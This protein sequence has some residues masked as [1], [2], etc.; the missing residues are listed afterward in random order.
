MPGQLGVWFEGRRAGTLTRSGKVH[1]TFAYDPEWIESGFPLSL[2]L[3]FQEKAFPREATKA[4]FDNLLPEQRIRALVSKQIQISGN[5]TFGFLETIGGECAGALTILPEGDRPATRPDYAPIGKEALGELIAQLPRRPLLAGEDGFR[6][7]LAGAQNKLPIAR[8]GDKFLLPVDGAA[9]THILKPAIDDLE[10]TIENE[11]FCMTLA[12]VAGRKVPEAEILD[13]YPRAYMVRR[14]DRVVEETG[15]RRLH[16]E[17][18]C[19]AL[20]LPAALKYQ[21]DGGPGFKQCFELLDHCRQP[22]EDRRALFAMAVFNHLIGNTDAH[23]KNFS[24]LYANPPQPDL[25]PFY[26][27]MCLGVYPGMAEKN[28]MK[29]GG[30][31]DPAFIRKRH[32]LR[33]ADEAGLPEA[34]ALS[35]LA[36]DTQMLP[37]MAEI[38]AEEFQSHYGKSRI[39]PKIVEFIRARCQ[40]V[41][42]RLAD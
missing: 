12:A 1:M 16:Q 11:A 33:L 18:F 23:A 10:G 22:D 37:I 25:A 14:Y 31:Y 30:S 29:I 34:E 21:N 26:D 36:H 17:D 9:S 7:S 28:A 15:V 8:L 20:G 35:L 40:Q 13:T 32:W 41:A 38:V 24:L 27:L 2:S 6:L 5:N 4:F 19:Q 42:D 3:P 39:V